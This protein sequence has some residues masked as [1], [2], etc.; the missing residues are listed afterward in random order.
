ME[1]IDEVLTDPSCVFYF[2][3]PDNLQNPLLRIEDG[4]IYLF[5]YIFII[6]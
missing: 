1:L 5:I 4:Y 3:Q 2:P 6:Y